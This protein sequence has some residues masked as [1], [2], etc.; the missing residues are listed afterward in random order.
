[1]AKRKEWDAVVVGSGIGGLVC[2]AYLAVSGLR[3]L[4]LEQHDVAGGNSHVFRRRRRY[5][6]DV[7]I[8]YLGDCGPGGLLPSVF[9]GLGLADRITYLPMDQDGFDRIVV[10]GLTLDVPAGWDGYRK[11]LKEALPGDAAGIDTFTSICSAVGAEGRGAL[12][13][14]TDLTDEQ[15][16]ARSPV[17]TAW[18]QR[19]LADLFDHC[20]LSTRARTVLAAHAP[21]YGLPPARCPLPTHAAII[22]HYLHGAYYPKG[23]G[24][25]LPAGLVE[26]IESHGGEVRTRTRVERI[27]VTAGRARGVTLTD[28]EVLTAPLVVSNADYT[29]TVQNLVGEEHFE[30]G[31]AE[32]TRDSTMSLP[33]AVLYV[34]LDTTL[35]ERP[36]ANLWWYR[37]TDIDTGFRQLAEHRIDPV[38]FLFVSFSSLKDP[39]ARNIAPE[40]HSNFQ[41]MTL[42]PPDHAYWG[43]D[44]APA[45]GGRYRRT[46]LYRRRKQE[47]TDAMLNAAEEALGPFRGHI[48]HLE[49]ATPLTHERYIH[50][51][52]GTPYGLAG[53]GATGERPDTTTG[54]EGLHV[55]G[56]SIRYGSGIE[57]V[58]TG[59]MMC[60][61]TILGRRLVPEVTRGAVLADRSLLPHRGDD[62]DP[63]AVSRGKARR[64][65]RG[66][67]RIDAAPRPA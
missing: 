31:T 65:A 63:L 66:L 45:D 56:T 10:P 53:W 43:A 57:G 34:A 55:V 60:A 20:G 14:E 61:S 39:G 59:A 50:S 13:S 36:N 35:P 38:P 21:T 3:V 5:E 67:A 24:Q 37:H 19:T 47:L 32:R 23:G 48:T 29:R 18:E 11:R 40:G 8:H 42:V 58:A 64:H 30:T 52:G 17:F 54:V 1:M 33:F 12:L 28:G 41:V 9:G 44:A 51:R 15:F 2:A 49:A 26:V 62:F 46:D 4:V 6:F 27:L 7:G 22:D 25:M 16:A